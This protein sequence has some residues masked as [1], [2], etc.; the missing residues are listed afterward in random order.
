VVLSALDPSADR[1][2]SRADALRA[3]RSA[4][5]ARRAERGA[6]LFLV[7][8][9]VSVLSA[10]GVFAMRSAS[11]ADVAAG[12]NR[13][14][15]QAAFLADFAARASATYMSRGDD[16][17]G[18]SADD[19]VSGCARSF[20]AANSK[21]SCTVIEGESLFDDFL[22]GQDGLLGKL[23]LDNGPAG[24]RGAIA[25]E[26]LAPSAAATLSRPGFESTHF[27]QL[28]VTAIAHVY[29]GDNATMTSSCTA[30]ARESLSEQSVRAH[31]IVPQFTK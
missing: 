24:V 2:A 20:L 22:Q 13:Q 17:V 3:L 23:A 16:F 14:G 5:A 21:A 28:T 7:V 30:G 15:V 26:V 8:M 10:I 4:L 6:A 29:P 1:A 25:T 11:L 27:K 9:V 12:Y 31:V 19:R 18:K